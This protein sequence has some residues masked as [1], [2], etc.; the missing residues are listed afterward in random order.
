[1][2]NSSAPFTDG[3]WV[4]GDDEDTG[5]GKGDPGTPD[6]DKEKNA[7]GD[8]V[9]SAPALDTAAD[10]MGDGSSDATDGL[11]EK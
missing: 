10:G 11:D 9:E 3:I 6:G 8:K 1:M 4:G 7:D 2:Y 5:E